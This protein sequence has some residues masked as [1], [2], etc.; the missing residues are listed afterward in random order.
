MA[1]VVRSARGVE[2]ALRIRAGS[3]TTWRPLLICNQVLPQ[4]LR[5]TLDALLRRRDRKS[6]GGPEGRLGRTLE[7][8]DEHD[9]WPR[10][11]RPQQIRDAWILSHV[12]IVRTPAEDQVPGGWKVGFQSRQRSAYLGHGQPELRVPATGD[13]VDDLVS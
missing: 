10:I 9:C 6:I 13:D 11:G 1:E 5:E 8:Y 2:D 7:R 4:K 12:I 3:K